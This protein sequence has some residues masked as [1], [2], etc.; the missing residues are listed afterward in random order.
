MALNNQA[1]TM[2]FQHVV[3]FLVSKSLTLLAF[4]ACYE[5]FHD[6]NSHHSPWYFWVSNGNSEVGEVCSAILRYIYASTS[7]YRVRQ[8][9]VLD[10]LSTTDV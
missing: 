2:V 10:L 1:G 8:I 7:V 4:A 6:V 5:H 9:N 3:V